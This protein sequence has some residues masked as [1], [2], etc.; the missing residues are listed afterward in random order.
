[1]I[2]GSVTRALPRL[3]VLCLFGAAVSAQQN[4]T[5]RDYIASRCQE[6]SDQALADLVLA[7]TRDGLIQTP[8]DQTGFKAAFAAALG[9]QGGR[10]RRGAVN[11]DCGGAGGAAPLAV[12]P[13]LECND[14]IGLADA[15]SP[16][17]TTTGTLSSLSDRD[18]YRMTLTTDSA[19]AVTVRGATASP[20]LLNLSDQDGRH[21][22]NG[23]LA[24][25][26][27]SIRTML[28]AGTY[29]VS[30]GYQS[31]PQGYTLT[32]TATAATIATL[33]PGGPP[34]N[35][36]ITVAGELR[37]WKL[38]LAAD[39]QIQV[40]AAAG[41]VGLDLHLTLGRGRGGRVFF[42]DDP[43][44][45]GVLDPRLTA[46][47]PAGTFYAFFGELAGRTGPFTVTA[48]ATAAP[49]PLVSCGGPVPGNIADKGTRELY[50]LVVPAPD[51]LTLGVAPTG[52]P[53]L[54]DAILE[55]YDADLG[56]LCEDD[57]NGTSFQPR[58]DL[59]LPAGLY[60]LVVRGY[61]DRVGSYD[62]NTTCNQSPSWTSL[63]AT[64][65]Q[66]MVPP[67][68]TGAYRLELLTTSPV[69]LTLADQSAQL[70]VMDGTGRLRFHVETSAL[71]T[72]VGPGTSFAGG[73]LATDQD[74][75]YVL[76]RTPTNTGLSTTLLAEA[77]LW[78]DSTGVLQS[79][80]KAGLFHVLL[81]G[82]AAAATPIPLLPP[83]TGHLL[84]DPTRLILVV[85]SQP[86]LGNGRRTW[87][88]SIAGY[89][90]V[91]QAIAIDLTTVTGATTNRLP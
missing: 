77:G 40:A 72:T 57:D 37:T 16:N 66:V 74:V 44:G 48:T 80:G 46:G 22:A 56:E 71:V 83:F 53:A 70:S 9:K 90:G 11:A 42:V 39:S 12:G 10:P 29:L 19:V 25:P 34:Q 69:Q 63:A 84:I 52:S 65:N 28:P 68:S 51:Q 49:L 62:L 4:R 36:A 35:D 76:V 91:L 88:F 1:M 23:H 75:L 14:T 86:L 45:T 81:A 30:V 32:T 5:F 26:F 8:T 33:V 27:R 3:A 82:R 89:G 61:N 20:P 13:E 21:I 78:T 73:A 31:S 2:G 64:S 41:S 67:G 54:N 6:F 58:L 7:A 50:R 38:T 87:P 55:L 18:V 59:P 43:G 15:I 85:D 47:L 79:L 60:Y 17:G 24:L